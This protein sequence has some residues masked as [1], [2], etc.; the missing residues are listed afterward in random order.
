MEE[1]AYSG[2]KKFSAQNRVEQEMHKRIEL[3]AMR[4]GLP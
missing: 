4:Y 2:D 1:N 3:K